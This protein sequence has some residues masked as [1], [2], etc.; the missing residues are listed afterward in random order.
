MASVDSHML[1]SA[2]YGSLGEGN[3]KMLFAHH[4]SVPYLALR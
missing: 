1:Q 2:R 4:A 3:A